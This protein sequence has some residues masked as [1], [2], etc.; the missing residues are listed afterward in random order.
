MRLIF[1]LFIVS[2]PITT[3]W[4]AK[5]QVTKATDYSNCQFG[6]GS[7]PYN[8]FSGNL[9]EKGELDLDR[10]APGVIKY[11]VSEEGN[12]KTV[13]LKNPWGG[14]GGSTFTYVLTQKEGR[15]DSLEF[16]HDA[17][18]LQ[19]VVSPPRSVFDDHMV[20]SMVRYA[21]KNDHCYVSQIASKLRSGLEIVTYDHE[22]CLKV[23]DTVKKLGARKVRECGSVNFAIQ[24]AINEAEQKINNPKKKLVLGSFFGMSANSNL[25]YTD[26]MGAFSAATSCVMTR[27]MYGMPVDAEADLL[28]SGGF[29]GNGPSAPSA[30][31]QESSEEESAPAQ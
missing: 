1:G 14:E 22:A 27:K 29:V 4:A 25:P 6:L 15:A 9:S 3:A 21:Y 8:F 2:V 19:K 12:V 20:G 11:E 5:S 23:L 31:E 13:V 30:G 10:K 16:K 17:A 24:N 18:R 26:M 7:S 28:P